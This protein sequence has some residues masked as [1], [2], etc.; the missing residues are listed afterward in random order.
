MRDKLF[1]VLPAALIVLA[2]VLFFNG[3]KE[4]CL[5]LHL[6]NVFMCIMLAIFYSKG[7]ELLIAFVLV[8]LLRILNVGMPTF[9]DLSIYYFPFIYLPVIIAAYLVWRVDNVEEGKGP[10][11]RGV[12]QFLNGVAMN[13]KNTFKWAY[14]PI[15]VVMGLTMSFVEYAVLKPEALIPDMS[16]GSI[17]LLFVVMVVFVGFGEEIVFRAILQRK[18]QER[19]GPIIAVLFSAFLFAM[20]HSGYESLP[21]LLYVFGVGIV[22]GYSFLRTKNLL[23]VALIHGM[24]NFFLFSFL[25]NGWYFLD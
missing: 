18:V 21:Y 12:W 13:E 16:F 17:A 1:L 7:A 15:A 4:A 22:L 23:F 2:E 25:P 19:T 10:G 24:I 6:F 20:M 3:M 5:M 14:L 11:A 9:F 8:S